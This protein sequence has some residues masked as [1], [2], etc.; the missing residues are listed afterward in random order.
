M[1]PSH[2]LETCLHADDINAAQALYCRVLGLEVD[3]RDGDWQA[4]TVS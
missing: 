4:V 2:V 1:C 3:A